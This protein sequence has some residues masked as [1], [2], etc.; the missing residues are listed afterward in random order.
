VYGVPPLKLTTTLPV[1]ARNQAVGMV[2]CFVTAAAGWV[3]VSDP[4]AVQPPVVPLA[5]LLLSVVCTRCKT[6]KQHRK[7]VKY[8]LHR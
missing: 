2:A 8:M 6:N 7:P 1:L 4:L 3:I 5:S